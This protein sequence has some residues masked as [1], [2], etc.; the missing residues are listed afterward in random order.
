MIK[1]L[2][3]SPF[4]S[5]KVGGVE[6]HVKAVAKLLRKKGFGVSIITVKHDNCLPETETIDGIEVFRIPVND[7]V[8]PDNYQVW[9]WLAR[10]RA[11]IKNAS[12][13]HCHDKPFWYLPFR[14]LYPSKPFY[15]T[16][17]GY[18]GYPLPPR[19]VFYRKLA[20]RLANGNI[21]IGS[22]IEKWYGIRADEIS[23]GAVEVSDAQD[24]RA[25]QH[26]CFAGRL[27]EDTG[28]LD[29]IE[30]L[31]ILKFEYGKEFTFHVCGDGPLRTLIEEL[32]QQYK[33]DVKFYG[34]VSDPETVVSDC[35]IAFASGYLAIL[36]SMVQKRLVFSL[37]DND[38][39][40]DY[41]IS[42]PNSSEKIVVS[43][44]PAELAQK[45]LHLTERRDLAETIVNQAYKWAMEQTWDSL[46]AKYLKLWKLA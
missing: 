33:L 16:F 29:Y 41:L 37:Y 11:L 38:L 21:C 44:L 19:A 4:Y 5:P 31:R 6:R 39:K 1:I 35:S 40:K 42:I 26:I 3:I 10:N 24:F 18:E 45:M 32:V 2:M 23:Y 28:I 14:F 15:M 25:N 17:H 7:P 8:S 13:V 22:F 43:A 46:L 9:S 27:A 30:A 36:E 20:A 34:F 12:L